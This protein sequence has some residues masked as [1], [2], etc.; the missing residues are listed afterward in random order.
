M[1]RNILGARIVQ[2][3]DPLPVAVL[4]DR[5]AQPT[6]ITVV[7]QSPAAVFTHTFQTIAK[8]SLTRML[9][10]TASL[11][12]GIHTISFYRETDIHKTPLYVDPTPIVVLDEKQYRAAVREAA[13]PVIENQ[14]LVSEDEFRTEVYQA[15]EYRMMAM[16]DVI[17]DIGRFGPEGGINAPLSFSY[18]RKDDERCESP[19]IALDLTL[20]V[21]ECLMDEIMYLSVCNLLETSFNVFLGITHIVI[22]AKIHFYFGENELLIGPSDGIESV[23]S[24]VN[25]RLQLANIINDIP[26]FASEAI[27]DYPFLE[28]RATLGRQ[29]HKY[30]TSDISP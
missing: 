1:I 6:T 24:R 4:H 18:R 26:D 15:I 11:E 27:F 8:Y 20:W 21:I 5:M 7:L 3:G 16:R 2:H 17:Y 30:A 25:E 13:Q 29:V 9:V 12:S 23:L 28:L 22:R 19:A 14:L 10:P